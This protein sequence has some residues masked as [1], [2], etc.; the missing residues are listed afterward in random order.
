MKLPFL[1]G[2]PARRRRRY[3]HPGWFFLLLWALTT[4][5][6]VAVYVTEG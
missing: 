5:I 4:V 2:R 6:A 1:L 3:F